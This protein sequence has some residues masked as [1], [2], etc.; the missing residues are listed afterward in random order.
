VGYHL[1]HATGYLTELGRPDSAMAER[2]AARLATAG[3][4]A[5]DRQDYRTAASLLSRAAELVRPIRLDLSLELEA[6]WTSG[7]YD[8]QNAA[9]AAEAAAGRA[10]AEG[11]SSGAMLGRAL[12]LF[13]QMAGGER[14]TIDE[15][16]ELLRAALLFE[17]QRNDPRRL[18][19][20]W[21]L[22]A[23][24]GNFLM[25]NEDDFEASM[26][27]RHYFRLAGDFRA[28]SHVEWALILG[29]RPADEALRMV[30]ELAAGRPAGAVDLPRAALL[31]ML[32]RFDEAWPLAEAR[33]DHLREV[34]GG[35]F[36]DEASGYLWLIATIEGDR[37]R[38]CGHNAELVEGFGAASV[39]ATFKTMLARDLCYLGRFEEAEP[40]LRRAQAVPPRASMRVMGPA[41]EALLLAERGELEHALTQARTAVAAGEA[42][43]DSPWLQGFA[44]EDLVTVLIRAGR[45]DETR[46]A[47]ARSLALWERKGCLPCA[48]RVRAQLDALGT[49]GL[50]ELGDDEAVA[51]IELGQGQQ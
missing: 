9:H 3:R 20:L 51:D 40:L 47:L 38:A 8:P 5:N 13:L 37:E 15:Q 35:S 44:Y 16:A 21:E 6:A 39:G 1:E 42:E 43:T 23:F 34:A 31:A 14:V 49:V 11:D 7:D 26:R 27:A 48:A 46:D 50:A 10:E 19:L 18:A 33:S 24:I 41:V 22:R 36:Q 25:R 12:S 45:I 17:E 32:G 4:R 30:D 28:D 29:P 2:A